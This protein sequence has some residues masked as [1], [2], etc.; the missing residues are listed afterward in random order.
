[1]GNVKFIRFNNR[2]KGVIGRFWS[3]HKTPIL[4]CFCLFMLGLATGVFIVGRYSANVRINNIVDNNLV[5]M[6]RGN[7]GMFGLFFN[8]MLW[9]SV[10]CCILIFFNFKPIMC[11]FTCI[12]LI[13]FGYIAGYNIAIISILFGFSGFISMFFF[14]LVFDL[15]IFALLSILCGVAIKRSI[16]IKKYGGHYFH[17]N[18]GFNLK[19]FY[20]HMFLAVSCV[21]FVKSLVMPAL[22][23]VIIIN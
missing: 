10:T 6:L 9:I 13:I 17:R 4:I 16:I 20:M 5:Q 3:Q 14:T 15:I 23:M 1:M 11:V 2:L 22:R 7:R 18:C 8:Q 12:P 19:K 21:V